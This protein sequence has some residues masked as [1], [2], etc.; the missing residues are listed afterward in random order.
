MYLLPFLCFL[1]DKYIA[2]VNF[3]QT[4]SVLRF[5]DYEGNTDLITCITVC[6]CKKNPVAAFDNTTNSCYCGNDPND[7]CNT[8][9]CISVS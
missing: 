7:P 1:S 9:T 2:S 8:G 3:Y 4:G 5:T 6:G